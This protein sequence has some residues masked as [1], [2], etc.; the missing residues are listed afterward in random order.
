MNEE[1]D[2]EFEYMALSRCQMDCETYVDGKGFKNGMHNFYGGDTV[3]EQ[4]KEMRRLYNL[5]PVKPE[6]LRAEQIDKLEKEMLE[7]ELGIELK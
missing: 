3:A 5:L 4:I 2:F 7:L 1:K 6:W